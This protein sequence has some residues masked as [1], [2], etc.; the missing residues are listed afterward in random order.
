MYTYQIAAYVDGIESV[1]ESIVIAFRFRLSDSDA[2]LRLRKVAKELINNP[3][4][5]IQIRTENGYPL[6]PIFSMERE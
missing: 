2:V 6:S 4:G 5:Q 3:V 1:S